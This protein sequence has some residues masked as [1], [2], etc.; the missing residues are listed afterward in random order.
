MKNIYNHVHTTV[1]TTKKS[2]NHVHTVSN[3]EKTWNHVQ[4]ITTKKICNHVHTVS[5]LAPTPFNRYLK[6]AWNLI[7]NGKTPEKGRT[8][9]ACQSQIVTSNLKALPNPTLFKSTDHFSW[10]PTPSWDLSTKSQTNGFAELS[11]Q[12]LFQKSYRFTNLNTP[13]QVGT[14][15]SPF[16]LARSNSL[17][18]VLKSQSNVFP[19]SFSSHTPHLMQQRVYT[20]PPCSTQNYFE[21]I[22][23]PAILCTMFSRLPNTFKQKPKSMYQHKVAAGTVPGL[24]SGSLHTFAH[25]ISA[26]TSPCIHW[27]STSAI[28]PPRDSCAFCSS[29]SSWIFSS[30]ALP[31]PSLWFCFS[32]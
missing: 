11:V 18:S 23:S 17:L 5:N 32:P 4:T 26:H 19:A 25:I 1:V 10:F 15:A 6:M 27:K 7:R 29:F 20:S 13:V 24:L 12:S 16:L 21:T 8:T 14:S 30:V 31:I 3:Y 2:C 9:C 28:F 22:L